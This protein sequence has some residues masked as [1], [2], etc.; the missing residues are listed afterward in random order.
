MASTY[1]IGMDILQRQSERG[2]TGCGTTWCVRHHRIRRSGLEVAPRGAL[3][4][5]LA[6]CGAIRAYR[7][8]S[9]NR[10]LASSA[11]R[12]IVAAASQERPGE[13]RYPWRLRRY[14]DVVYTNQDARIRD[15]RL[16]MPQGASGTLRIRLPE[17]V[18]L[19]G[20]LM[21][22]RLSYGVVRIICETPDE[23]RHGDGDRRGPGREYFDRRDRWAQGHPHQWAR[24]QGDHPVPQQAARALPAGPVAQEKGS[25]RH[26]RLQRRKYAM[27]DKT[28]DASVICATKRHGRWL[29]RFPCDMLCGRAVQRGGAT[30]RSGAGATGEHRLHAQDHPAT[31]L[32]NGGAITLS[33]AYSSQTCPVCGE[34]S[35]HR[36]IYLCP[37]AGPPARVTP[38]AR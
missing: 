23:P 26:K 6:A 19:P 24:R 21:E 18:T 38:S 35:K 27:L 12:L 11:K 3:A 20:R 33:E 2:C 8:R 17:A 31:R 5:G 30:Y 29:R 13:A 28:S 7:R 36:R 22:V 14:R 1:D 16:I 25:R 4:S 37:S 9:P 15:G 34:R 10:S 32:Q